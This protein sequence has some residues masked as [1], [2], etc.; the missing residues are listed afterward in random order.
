MFSIKNLLML[1]IASFI[2]FKVGYF[3]YLQA[4]PFVDDWTKLPGFNM[5]NHPHPDFWRSF[6]EIVRNENMTVE[7]H[8]VITEDGYI[9]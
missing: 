9:N 3:A 4:D 5:L 7:S 2:T 1:S 6:E 8:E